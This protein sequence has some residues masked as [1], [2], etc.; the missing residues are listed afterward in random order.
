M[1][2]KSLTGAV[3]LSMRGKSCNIRPTLKM[4]VDVSRTQAVCFLAS[5]LHEDSPV[6]PESAVGVEPLHPRPNPESAEGPGRAPGKTLTPEKKQR[7]VSSKLGPSI[8]QQ[9]RGVRPEQEPSG[10]SRSGLTGLGIPRLLSNP[11]PHTTTEGAS[12]PPPPPGPV[13][14]HGAAPASKLPVKGLTN[15][16][17]QTLALNDN[18]GTMAAASSSAAG[19][20]PNERPSRSSAKPVPPT[21]TSAPSVTAISAS[22]GV[23]KLHVTRGRATLQARTSA[24]NLKTTT[25]SKRSTA[26]T[27]HHPPAKN[28][29]ATT[30]PKSQHS[31]QSCSSV[32]LCRGQT[33]GDGCLLISEVDKNKQREASRQTHCNGVSQCDGQKQKHQQISSDL[34]AGVVNGNSP[35]ADFKNNNA[36][37]SAADGRTGSRSVLKTTSRPQNASKASAADGTVTAKHN[38]SKEHAEKKKQAVTQLRRMLIQG[39]KRVEALATVIQ[40]IFSEREEAVKQKG[41]IASELAN[42]RDEL[43]LSTQCCKRLQKEKEEMRSS[44][45]EAMKTLEG[46]HQEELVQLENRLKSFYQREWDK[47]HQ[48]Y[49]EEADKCC[50]L[51]EEQVERLR[52]QQ[53]AERENQEVIQTQRMDSLKL[54]YESCI[55]ELK[56]THE[57]DMENLEKSLK[58]TETSL[59][60]KILPL[61]TEKEALYKKLKEEE[62]DGKHTPAEKYLD[63]H[64]LYLEQ[65]LESLKAVLEIRNNQLHQKEKKLMEMDKLMEANIK[66]EECLKKVQQENEDYQARMDKYAAL[67]KQLSSEQVV[68]QQSLQ[69]ESKVNKRLSMENEELLW[70][71][72]NCD[73]LP[74]PC[75]LSPTS[76]FNS[77][78]NSAAFPTAAPLSPR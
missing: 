67:S 25:V 24:P 16:S 36:I 4:A 62:E 69:K 60:D 17:P 53:Q 21:S 1:R 30:R 2:V 12:N 54:H 77:P 19:T 27:P 5:E 8:R 73:L 43:V 78:R 40:H 71:L 65:E 35:V 13:G 11:K 52:K 70:K 31:L 75:R 20:S 76:P 29:P 38:Q 66:L 58:R 15:L 28:T 45:E 51:M 47:V 59:S 37:S 34:T 72:Q 44:F 64:V 55:Q 57:K 56:R 61:S 74:S 32:R 6:E 46:Q 42:L 49:Q 68:L 23:P 39:N 50:M 41:E 3:K 26:K 18:N 14:K 7:K 48:I 33:S 9:E 10:S 22:F 63:S